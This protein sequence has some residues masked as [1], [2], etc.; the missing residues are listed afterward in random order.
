MST[1]L[2]VISIMRRETT[3]QPWYETTQEFSDYFQNTYVSSGK[4]LLRKVK[5]SVNGLVKKKI[6]VWANLA[7]QQA[8]LN[9]PV[10]VAE[11]QRQKTFAEN[12][13]IRL[14]SK[15]RVVV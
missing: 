10:V 7:E 11:I 15:T 8:Y 2:K 5:E 14:N 3:D 9:D 12:N 13:N 6:V 1:P 4:V